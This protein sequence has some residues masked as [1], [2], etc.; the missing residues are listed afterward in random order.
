MKS[1]NTVISNSKN[2][3]ALFIFPPCIICSHPFDKLKI[4]SMGVQIQAYV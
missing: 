4:I 1:K 3:K 2:E